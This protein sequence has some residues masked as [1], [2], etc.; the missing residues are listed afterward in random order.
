MERKPNNPFIVA[1]HHRR[2]KLSDGSHEKGFYDHEEAIAFLES[3]MSKVKYEK[4]SPESRNQYLEKY[5]TW[6]GQGQLQCTRETR[7]VILLY[8]VS[9]FYIIPCSRHKEI[10]SDSIS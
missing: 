2:L 1:W 10:V 9:H 3:E 5:G 6:P 7:C 4:S 8:G